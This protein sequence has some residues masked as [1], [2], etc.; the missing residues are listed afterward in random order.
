MHLHRGET[1][2]PQEGLFAG[3]QA[4]VGLTPLEACS[5]QVEQLRPHPAASKPTDSGSHQ[6]GA[7]QAQLAAT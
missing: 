2:S 5:W 3:P 7:K 4:V 1:Q 6:K